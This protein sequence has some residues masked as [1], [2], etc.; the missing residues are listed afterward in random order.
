M[1]GTK[2]QITQAKNLAARAARI[3]RDGEYKWLAQT[4]GLTGEKESSRKIFALADILERYDGD[5]AHVTALLGG[6]RYQKD[7]IAD[8]L[9][10]FDRIRRTKDRPEFTG[11]LGR[12]LL[13]TLYPMHK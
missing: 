11:D 12:N 13:R 3:L 10:I 4:P 8:A 6:I 2:T 5:A 9:A 7:Y 1:T